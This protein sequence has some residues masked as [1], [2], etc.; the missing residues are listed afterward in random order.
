[1]GGLTVGD[2]WGIGG[3][4]GG[5]IWPPFLDSKLIS[6]FSASIS[7]A[8]S[9]N[10]QKIKE[11]RVN[12]IHHF[13]YINTNI[14]LEKEIW[15]W[16]CLLWCCSQ[17]S[18]RPL[19]PLHLTLVL[20]NFKPFFYHTSSIMTLYTV[21]VVLWS[22]ILYCSW[23]RIS[24]N[25]ERWNLNFQVYEMSLINGN[26]WIENTEWFK[27]N[28]TLFISHISHKWENI[29]N[30]FEDIYKLWYLGRIW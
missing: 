29:M 20:L 5:K 9:W 24:K 30:L 1:M 7:C 26:T 21:L 15:P 3:W 22:C 23:N 8:W 19:R 10:K 28:L 4:V 11:L 6:S 14:S 12:F 2:P 18:L 17:I 27:I 25:R 16:L 13:I